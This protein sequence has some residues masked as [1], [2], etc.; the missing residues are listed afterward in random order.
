MTQCHKTRIKPSRTPKRPAQPF[1]TSQKKS[2][3]AFE[4]TSTGAAENDLVAADVAVLL[5]RSVL[6]ARKGQVRSAL[7]FHVLH[8]EGEC[9]KPRDDDNDG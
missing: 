7:S 1:H 8:P 9:N 6:H 5:H 3:S 2:N 4:L